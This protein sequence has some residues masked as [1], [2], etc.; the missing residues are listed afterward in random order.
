MPLD[1]EGSDEG[2]AVPVFCPATTSITQVLLQEVSL[3][4]LTT[5]ELWAGRMGQSV[6]LG[7]FK[8]MMV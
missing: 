3:P 1:H 4:H 7:I 5:L 2:I 8:D 6:T